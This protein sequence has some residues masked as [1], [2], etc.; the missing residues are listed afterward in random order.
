YTRQAVSVH[1]LSELKD[2]DLTSHP[3]SRS[4]EAS[5]VPTHPPPLPDTSELLPPVE[6]ET[7]IFKYV[8]K[9]EP[10]L[11]SFEDFVAKNA[12]KWYSNDW[13]EEEYED[14]E[15]RELWNGA[16]ARGSVIERRL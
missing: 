5:L 14:Q 4:D 1:P 13:N 12:R 7:Y 8:R 3:L 11:W 16:D 10:E 15:L 2:F 6:A 9:L